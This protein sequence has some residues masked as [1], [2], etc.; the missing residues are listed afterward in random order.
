MDRTTSDSQPRRGLGRL[1]AHEVLE[2]IA[3]LVAPSLAAGAVGID[4]LGHPLA[5]V[6]LAGAMMVAG[7]A[8]NVTSFPLHLMPAARAV[9]RIAMPLAGAALVLPIAAHGGHPI[10]PSLLVQPVLAAW[11]IMAL[12]TWVAARFEATTEVRVAVIGP[13]GKAVALRN[14]LAAAGIHGYRVIGAI[15]PDPDDRL[16]D[17]WGVRVLGSLAD[18]REIVQRDRIDLLVRVP[19]GGPAVSRDAEILGQIAGCCL[20][21]KVRLIEMTQF[22]EDMLGHVPAGTIGASWFQYMLHPRFHSASGALKRATDIAFGG[23]GLLL[24]LPI[25]AVAAIAIKIGDGGPIFFRQRRIGTGGR[26]FDLIK[27]RT[28]RTGPP[29][30]KAVWASR[31]DDRITAA[32]RW[33]RPT[34]IDELPQFWQVVRGQMTMVGPRPEQ[35]EKVAG[36]E[37]LIPFYDRRHLVKPGL[38]GWAQVRCGYAGSELGSAWKLCHDLYYLKHR[39]LLSDLLVM[40]ETPLAIGL[41]SQYDREVPDRQFV[42]GS[43]VMSTRGSQ[44]RLRR[45]DRG[46]PHPSPP[47]VFAG[48]DVP[49]THA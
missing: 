33:L 5:P 11:M 41:G 12:G 47:A 36:L 43:G 35:P 46:A 17:G 49:G 16:P 27:L 34:H 2:S 18:L 48:G 29:V 4:R 23:A 25:L 19:A 44:A 13:P 20:D 22:Y 26:E 1:R 37:S 30:G 42:L 40:L 28:M 3:F 38:T 10:H 15:E 32:G 7:A 8:L 24:S 14:E 31:D 45:R 39:S 21:L 9:L 6:E